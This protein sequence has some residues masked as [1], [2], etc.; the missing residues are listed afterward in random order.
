[1][2]SS[3]FSSIAAFS[4]LCLTFV[5]INADEAPEVPKD[6]VEA[7]AERMERR[8]AIYFTNV[9]NMCEFVKTILSMVMYTKVFK[10]FLIEIAEL[11]QDSDS[12]TECICLHLWAMFNAST[13][14]QQKTH[15]IILGRVAEQNQQNTIKKN[16][17]I[18]TVYPTNSGLREDLQQPGIIEKFILTVPE[19]I[20]AEL[21]H[22]PSGIKTASAEARQ[23]AISRRPLLLHANSQNKKKVM[24]RPI[25]QRNQTL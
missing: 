22:I 7:T 14:V 24:P 10:Y 3:R 2:L 16:S 21:T 15:R 23:P 17:S 9:F 4:M 13:L 6:P 8:K 11:V 1:I 19:A 12:C 5:M 18:K 20:S 25:K